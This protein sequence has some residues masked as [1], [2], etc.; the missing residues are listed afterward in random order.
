MVF[1]RIECAGTSGH[2]LSKYLPRHLS[3]GFVSHG[4]SDQH[5]VRIVRCQCFDYSDRGKM[6]LIV[7]GG[8]VSTAMSVVL[9]A[10]AVGVAAAGGRHRRQGGFSLADLL[11]QDGGDIPASQQSADYNFYNYDNQGKRYG[12]CRMNLQ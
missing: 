2:A 4:R 5:C 11:A 1:W 7:R 10:L 12:P 9:L 8:F 3:F 6:S